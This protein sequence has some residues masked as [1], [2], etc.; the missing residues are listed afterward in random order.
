MNPCIA[1]LTIAFVIVN[2]RITLLVI[3]NKF[4]N[5]TK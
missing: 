4:K 1:I 2:D 5:P 3:F